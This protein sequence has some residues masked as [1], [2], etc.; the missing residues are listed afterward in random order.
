MAEETEQHKTESTLEHSG[1][2]KNGAKAGGNVL[3]HKLGPLPVWGW[4]AIALVTYVLYKHF[5]GSGSSTTQVPIGTVSNGT[6]ALIGGNGVTGTATGTTSTTPGLDWVNSAFSALQNLGY[7]N[8]TISD[9]LQAYSTGQTLNPT[10]Y[11][12]VE[13]AIRLIGNAPTALGNPV[14]TP[15]GAPAPSAPPPAATNSGPTGAPPGLPADLI[16]AMQSNGEHLV[17]TVFDPTYNEWV[18]LTQKGGVYALNQNGGQGSGFFGSIFSLAPG[19]FTGRTAQQLIVNPD[20][21]YTIVDATGSTYN[22]NRTGTGANYANSP[23]GA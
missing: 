6:G 4:F 10:Q 22:F 1:Q 16:G 23:S 14:Q 19:T 2:S 3:T 17:S 18:Y 5:K 9:A 12:I 20:G 7:S 13:A 11:G 8:N 21:G 15:N